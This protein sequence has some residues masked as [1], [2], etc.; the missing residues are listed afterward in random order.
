M[1]LPQNVTINNTAYATADLPEA[2]RVQLSNIQIVD[3]EISRLQQ[4]LAIFQTARRAY[5]DA[6]LG[7]LP[8]KSAQP[9]AAPAKP[10][11]KTAK[12]RAKKR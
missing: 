1:S 3:T 5:A 4:S 9:A 6:L 8:A 12:P 11:A 2:A 10:E 7:M